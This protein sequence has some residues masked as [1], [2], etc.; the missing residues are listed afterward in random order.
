MGKSTKALAQAAQGKSFRRVTTSFNIAGGARREAAA[1]EV[2]RTGLTRTNVESTGNIMKLVDQAGGDRR[3][4][5]LAY[6]IKEDSKEV[7]IYVDTPDAPGAMPT[8]IYSKTISFHLGNAFEECPALRPEAKASFPISDVTTDA[9]GVPCVIVTLKAGLD[10][11][12]TR[13]TTTAAQE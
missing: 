4:F 7:A 3:Q 13:T 12:K 9:E 2:Y 10:S 6:G 1:V 8:R 5:H 11:R